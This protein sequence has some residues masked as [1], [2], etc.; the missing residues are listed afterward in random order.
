M[1]K[2]NQLCM[3]CYARKKSTEIT[4]MLKKPQLSR[5]YLLPKIQAIEKKVG[6]CGTRYNGRE[7]EST[8]ELVDFHLKQII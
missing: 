2:S 7:T 4:L 6:I 8:L 3:T 1:K 5:F